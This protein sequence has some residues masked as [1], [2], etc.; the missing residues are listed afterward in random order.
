MASRSEQLHLAGFLHASH[1]VIHSHAAWR[2]PETDASGFLTPE[3]YQGIARTL[4]RGKFDLLFFADV[5]CIADQYRGGFEYTVE[6]GG[7]SATMLDP[8]LVASVIGAATRSIGVGVTRSTTYFQPYDLARAFATL[9]H[10][11][12]G[13]AAWNVVTSASDSEAANF[14]LAQH[15][16]H[17]TRYARAEDFIQ[18]ASAL[19]AS[20]GQNALRLDKQRGV[21]ADASQVRRID[22]VGPYVKVRGPLSVPRSPQG[23]PVIIQAG[24]S[25]RGRDF[26]ARHAEVVFTSPTNASAMK[27]FYGDL[28]T[29]VAAAGRNPRSCVILPAV[30]PFVA[31]SESEAREKQALNHELAD[32]ELGLVTLSRNIN[33]DLFQHPLDQPLGTLAHNRGHKSQLEQVLKLSSDEN[34]TLRQLG[35]RFAESR[36]LLQLV[37]TPK[38]VAD[39]L[40]AL[41]EEETGDGFVISPASLPVAY[42]DFVRLVVP[43]LQRR[44]LHRRE[45]RGH[46]LRDHLGLP[47]LD[48]ARQAAAGTR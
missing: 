38:Q 30:M 43:E 18:A 8:L 9:D 45:Y 31:E 29:R 19:W 33:H 42:E 5:L 1:P 37:G 12:R 48:D 47:A 36:L 4:E 28:K 46:T 20:W 35:K 39:Q 26:A 22:H 16:E 14:G 3:Y 6:H 13:R 34:L 7:Q 11:T 24:S 23:R 32:P 44:G 25:E 27:E 40:Q 21:F 15:L 17:D 41:F 10:L 2:L